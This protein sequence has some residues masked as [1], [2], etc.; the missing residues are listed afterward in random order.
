MEI[1]GKVE[2][3][4][5]GVVSALESHYYMDMRAAVVGSHELA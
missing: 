5:A 1:P 3:I 2:V 4:G